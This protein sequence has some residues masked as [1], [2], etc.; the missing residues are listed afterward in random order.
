MV[1]MENL[2][3][4]KV[5]WAS[6]AQAELRAIR[7]EVFIQEQHVPDA[8]EWDNEDAA[9]L[10]LLVTHM[11]GQSV[12]CARII[13]SHKIGRMAVLKPY[14]NNGIGMALLQYAILECKQLAQ[15]NITLSA[16][17]HVIGFYQNAGFAVISQ[18][19]LDAGIWHVDMQLMV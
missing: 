18:P 9:A 1:A 6:Q 7:T 13:N 17:V 8:L 3:I 19:Y 16:Q 2:S 14:R 11:H 10:H 12:A 4:Q 15:P 5:D